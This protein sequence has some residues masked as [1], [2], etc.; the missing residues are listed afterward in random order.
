MVYDSNTVHNSSSFVVGMTKLATADAARDRCKAK[1]PSGQ[2]N[3]VEK[4]FNLL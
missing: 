1:T 2:A 4:T 3:A